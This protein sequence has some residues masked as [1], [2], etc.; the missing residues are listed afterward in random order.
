MRLFSRV[1]I[2]EF[3]PLSK[4][5]PQSGAVRAKET[6]STVFFF[7]HTA[8]RLHSRTRPRIAGGKAAQLCGPA[9]R[10]GLVRGKAL[11]YK[12]TLQTL[13]LCWR[14]DSLPVHNLLA[15][16]Y[17]LLML[18]QWLILIA[19]L[20]AMLLGADWLVRGCV[21]LAR[22]FGLSEFIV[23][24]FIIG[25]GTSLPELLVSVF[26]SAENIGGMAVGTNVSSNIIN[27][28]GVL[29]IG[30]LARPIIFQAKNY[31]A[32]LAFMLLATAAFFV[33]I[34]TGTITRIDGVF[35]VVLFAVYAAHCWLFYKRAGAVAHT[36]PRHAGWAVPAQPHLDGKI[37][38]LILFGI[39]I[40]YFG[41]DSFM[42]ALQKISA[43]LNLSP[44]MAGIL[45]VAPGTATPELIITILAAAKHQPQIAVGNIIG[46]NMMNIVLVIAAGALIA[47]LPVEKH[48]MNYDVWIMLVATAIMCVSIWRGKFSRFTGF[49]YL[50]LLAAY[51]WLE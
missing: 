34:M 36:C 51:F 7:A 4:H 31:K 23:S 24:V 29:G 30:A 20:A 38:F 13:K 39:L 46:S 16:R 2:Q 1:I 22:S 45:I 48:V 27:I 47:P 43:H 21:R 37:A 35:L 6:R 3:Q 5:K 14:A 8:L 19:S 12:Y 40:L 28:F 33:F 42:I 41:S 11:F 26:S 50:A 10:A 49:I 17:D 25:I 32:D 9:A 15:I 18:V 44:T